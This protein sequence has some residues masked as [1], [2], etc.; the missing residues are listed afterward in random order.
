MATNQNGGCLSIV[1]LLSF[2]AAL[3]GMILE[4]FLHLDGQIVTIC[5][6]AMVFLVLIG[7][8]IYALQSPSS[9]NDTINENE[10]SKEDEDSQD[11]SSLIAST[12][13][14]IDDNYIDCCYSTANR[15]VGYVEQVMKD[16][17]LYKTIRD[18]RG[19]EV[20]DC[21]MFKR[22]NSRVVIIILHDLWKCYIGSGNKVGDRYSV[23][24]ICYSLAVY[25]MMNDEDFF[26]DY[27]M[28]S[29]GQKGLSKNGSDMMAFMSKLGVHGF[30]G[31][32][33]FLMV[34]VYDHLGRDPI[35]YKRFLYDVT[36]CMNSSGPMTK[37]A[38]NYL[39]RLLPDTAV[40]S[41]AFKEKGERPVKETTEIECWPKG[42]DRLD[43][44]VGL[45]IVKKE[46]RKL[47]S[48]VQVQQW[49]AK[50]GLNSPVVSYHCVFTGNPGTGKT[51]VAR[52]I[53]DIYKELGLL[54]KG[55]LVETDRSG[56]VAEYVGQTAV[57][58]N[59]IIDKALDGVLFI[60]EA[61]S[62]MNEDKSDYGLEAISTL[63][64][65]ME[66][67]RNRLVV[68][69]AGYSEE[70]RR[71]IDSN[72]GLRSRFNRIF[73]FEDYSAEELWMIFE[74]MYKK[75]DYVVEI[76]ACEKIKKI[77]ERAVSSGNKGFGNAR[78]V[79]NL[80]E[81]ILENQALRL[82]SKGNT[83]RNALQTIIVDDLWDL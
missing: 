14:G 41:G 32:M 72:P 81:K 36:L 77:F 34:N 2:T 56:L 75:H 82:A 21:N 71:F 49:R 68:I 70:M 8:C 45:E 54:K 62:L 80:F 22:K 35:D 44:L 59:K 47:S 64:K 39:A 6:I 76:E 9:K 73:H 13:N 43:D 12:S 48:F 27:L 4:Q 7:S 55:H 15:I 20:I 1:I 24:N 31:P 61:Y 40:P 74:S 58:T 46:V 79:R 60:D 3:T 83:D 66:D 78:Y 33:S 38:K 63:L 16:K 57:K 25:K 51:T 18:I 65:R 30:E 67:D 50:E 37:K 19:L 5:V 53:A 28:T 26:R 17:E 69:I 23:S 29:E 11:E 52:I 10:N 42:I